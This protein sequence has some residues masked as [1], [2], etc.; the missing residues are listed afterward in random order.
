MKQR[1]VAT[2]L[3]V[4][5][6][7]GITPAVAYN[8]QEFSDVPSTFWAYEPIME[9]ADA[10][11]INGTGKGVFSPALTVS[12]AQFLTLVGRVAFPEIKVSAGES[13][14]V[15]Y[16]TAAQNAGWIDGTQ[17]DVSN[18][19]DGGITRYDMAVVLANAGEKLNYPV[20]V[21]DVSEIKDYG[22]IPE[23][24][25]TAVKAVYGQGLIKGNSEGNFMGTNTMTRAEVATVIWRM[26]KLESVANKPDLEGLN[27]KLNAEQISEKC[28]PA[29]F[30]IDIYG[31]N[32]ALAGSGSGFFISED[33]LAI[34]NFHVAAN[35]ELLIVTTHDGKRYSDVSIIDSD[36]DNDLALL[37]IEGGPFPYLELGDSSKV[38]Q[39]QKVFAIGSPLGL[40][41][42]ISTGIVSNAKRILNDMTYIQISVP[43]APGS[44]GG[45]LLDESGKVVGITSAGYANSTGDLNLAI[46]SNQAAKLNKDST[47]AQ[48]LFKEEFYPDSSKIY[49]F[50]A[51]SGV[52]EISSS[53][54]PYGWSYTYDVF[55]FHEG[56][57]SLDPGDCYAWT[58]IY[59]CAAL[60]DKGFERV[61]A[62]ETG[63]GGSFES[64][65]EIV[66][67]T[68]DL[69]EERTIEIITYRIPEYYEDLPEL[70]DLGWYLFLD[71]AD[72]GPYEDSF[73]YKY[74]WSD[75]YSSD[76]FLGLL[77]LYF[78]LLEIEGYVKR[79]DDGKT[80]LYEGNGVSA[81]YNIGK[82]GIWVDAKHIDTTPIS[83]ESDESEEVASISQASMNFPWYLYSN[84]G[85]I[86]LGKVTTNRYDS[87][88]IWN[89]YGT[90]G[91]KYS[92]NSIWNEY[93]TY[94]SK[95]SNQSAFNK[96][97]SE[98]PQIVDKDGY[99][100][101][102]LTE[103][104]Y[105]DGG[106]PITVVRQL[107]LEYGQ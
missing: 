51:F 107:L 60:L 97:A 31:F 55:D 104:K 100:V 48:I 57:G 5:L 68:I 102:Y 14:Y 65:D 41:N 58:M 101:C 89:E 13:W 39:G 61:E 99:F 88:S 76:V 80:V 86:Y 74:I 29:V 95:Y 8:T 69:E 83:N 96:Y 43:I 34:T 93:G 20:G 10:G 91:N 75:F 36:E 24:Y 105:L 84:D 37:K 56:D 6:I 40:D 82:T 35:S 42:T 25:R 22:Q 16:V 46:P 18:P 3:A 11:I 54:Y 85:K 2:I 28:A 78:E 12:A 92:S 47:G 23:N 73:M 44:S 21:V 17:I 52:K 50:G 59:Y 15:P 94:G 87:E 32:G 106:Y 67:V 7:L 33:G 63:L 81:F 90:Y 26:T 45:A 98:P 53:I 103:N 4:S 70:P 72:E 71:P 30:Y 62:D 79:Y 9:M 1:L 49:D 64:E 66:L 38:V 19:A 77:E 27:A